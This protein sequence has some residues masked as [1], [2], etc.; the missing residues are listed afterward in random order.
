[1]VVS[2][3]EMGGGLSFWH[4]SCTRQRSS[5]PLWGPAVIQWAVGICM[6]VEVGY[7]Q[8]AEAARSPAPQGRVQRL[9]GSYLEAEEARISLEH[10]SL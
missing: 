9:L 6:N 10:N 3:K 1:M 5:M 2:S 4:D 8:S 7:K